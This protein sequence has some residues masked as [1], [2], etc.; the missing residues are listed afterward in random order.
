MKFY[1]RDKEISQLTEID[2]L[3]ESNPQFTVITGRRRSGK[4]HL[5][6]NV[7]FRYP[8]LYF[9]AARKA[10]SFLCQDFQQE[11]QEKL[12]I[13]IFGEISSFGRLFE[14]LMIL[15]KERS[16]TLIIDEFQ[17]FMNIAPS[18]YGE[19]QHF[20]DIH[21][22]ASK[23]NLIVCGSV[24][25]L[26]HKIFENSKE[27]LFGRATQL[28]TVRSFGIS[29]LKEILA[30]HAPG[31]SSEDL[32]ALYSFSSGVAKYVQMFMDN[33]AFTKQAMIDLMIKEDSLFL[34]EGKN[35]LI[36]E[37]GKEYAV[38]FT[39]LS[40]IARGENTRG[41][42]EAIV[43]REIGGYLTKME[44]D[45]NL[46][47]KAIPI[48]SKVETKNVRYIIEDNFLTFW[49]RFVYKYS[50]IIEIGGFKQLKE[51]IVRDYQVFSGKILERY[52]RTKIMEEGNV[53]RIGGFWDRKGENEIDLVVVNELEEKAEIIEV[54]RN[55][56]SIN[57]EKLREKG[58]YLRK[59]TGELKD[60]SIQYKG[61][62]MNDM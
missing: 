38:Y 58:A 17:E 45:Y 31:Y 39:I 42:I 48:F 15:S 1:N 54:K 9:F 30:D 50:H 20:W 32:L 25:S 60:Y 8:V 61:L 6:L 49:F 33:G 59:A 3:T 10:E 22:G 46:I 56:G 43:K 13:Q 2:R 44:R 36:D 53:T 19:M 37:F 16:F 40:S 47:S 41:K 35:M 26:I 21:K 62:S 14:Y 29:T 5:L 55:P 52:F 34:P 18:V 12:G 23:I 27:P 4:T 11:I 28:L 57:L 51:I 7:P 24:N